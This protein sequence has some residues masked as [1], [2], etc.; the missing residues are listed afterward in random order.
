MLCYVYRTTGLFGCVVDGKEAEAGLKAIQQK[1]KE[2]E[3]D[4]QRRMAHLQITDSGQH[5]DGLALGVQVYAPNV[6]SQDYLDICSVHLSEKQAYE[7]IDALKN[8]LSMRKYDD[9]T[10]EVK[11]V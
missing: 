5:H 2:A 6:A 1:N 9:E 4:Y 7:I 8:A 10:E 3:F 11:K